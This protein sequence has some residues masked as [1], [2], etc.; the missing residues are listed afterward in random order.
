M[1]P[2][3]AFEEGIKDIQEEGMK[4][5]QEESEEDIHGQEPR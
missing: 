1:V 3:S 5:V 4:D 2:G